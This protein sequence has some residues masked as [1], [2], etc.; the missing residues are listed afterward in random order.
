[1]P[2]TTSSHDFWSEKLTNSAKKS[3]KKQVVP[4]EHTNH[5]DYISLICVSIIVIFAWT[6]MM[7]NQTE[8]EKR[9]EAKIDK[10]VQ[11]K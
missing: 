3:K 11:S 6:L 10:L 7:I 8:M 9:I 1:M 4:E 5:I 2:T